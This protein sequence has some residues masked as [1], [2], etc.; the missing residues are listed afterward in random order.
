MT[1]S[2]DTLLDYLKKC[3]WFAGKARQVTDCAVTQE[4][5]FGAAT[6]WIVEVNYS[7]GDSERYQLPV[8]TVGE[9]PDQSTEQTLIVE[10]RTGSTWSMRSI[11]MPF[12]V[13]FLLTSTG[14]NLWVK[15]RLS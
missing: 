6:L 7:E 14:Q 10:K 1:I 13:L 12:A 11:P 15:H 8:A 9:M 5:P 4:I 2:S 3:R